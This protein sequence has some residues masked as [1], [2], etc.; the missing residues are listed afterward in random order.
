MVEN[1][2]LKVG[3]GIGFSETAARLMSNR[4]M[5]IV[6]VALAIFLAFSWIAP[7]FMSQSVLVDMAR[8]SA[9]LGIL[10]V[11]MTFLF[12][13]GEFDLSIGSH[14]AFLLI[15]LAK[16]T[17]IGGFDPW[18][19]SAAIIVM[20]AAI[21]AV[22]GVLVTRIGLPSFIATL[23]MLILLRGLA[24]TL[25]SGWVIPVKNTDV[26]FYR[27]IRAD[28]LGTAM[29]NVFVLML[30]V[31]AAG[32]I[33]LA[34]TKFGS[35]IYAT[36][37]NREA[38]RNSGINT[39]RV[40]LICFM[41]MGALVGLCSALL[42]GRIGLA[43][44][45]A[46]NNLELQVIAAVIIGGTSLF[47]GRGTVLGSLVGVSILCMITSGIILVGVSQFWDGVATA[48]VILVAAGLNILVQRSSVRLSRQ[49]A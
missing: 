25:S 42:Y 31:A 44:L 20:G 33:V 4:D 18:L 39:R 49:E 38:A 13:G 32:G 7:A 15:V 10:A 35:D 1:K 47:G 2:P 27:I 46:G 48:V 22:N 24:Q 30:M 21:G 16:L 28:F 43:T 12:I 45:S 8:R 36:G 34:K 5:A 23:G 6:L 37:G 3:H 40:L 19:A 29:P 11:G 41:A 9:I 26:L 14:F 17:E